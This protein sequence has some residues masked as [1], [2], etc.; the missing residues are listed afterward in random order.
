M[1]ELTFCFKTFCLGS[2]VKYLLLYKDMK[3]PTKKK[4]FFSEPSELPN[5]CLSP[6]PLLMFPMFEYSSFIYNAPP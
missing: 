6:A 1:Y 5:V 3:E 4:E 2:V